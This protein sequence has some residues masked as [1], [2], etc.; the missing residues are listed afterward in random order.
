M[1]AAAHFSQQAV[2]A[3]LA[4]LAALEGSPGRAAAL[5]WR[6]GGLLLIDDFTLV[7]LAGNAPAARVPPASSIHN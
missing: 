6:T 1:R 4:N 5:A 3:A 7:G 2:T